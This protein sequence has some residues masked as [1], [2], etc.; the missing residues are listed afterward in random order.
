MHK[1]LEAELVS[2]AHSILKMENKDDVQVLHKK[3]QEIY[4]KLS[5]LKFVDEFLD[6]KPTAVETNKE[7]VLEE[8]VEITEKVVK[9]ETEITIELEEINNDEIVF[10]P[11]QK[12]VISE[13][14]IEEIFET[15]QVF[16]KDDEKDL[17]S[18]QISLEEEFKDAISAD[19]ATNL[20][21]KVTKETPIVEN[22][23]T[24]EIK[25]R[26]LNDALFNKNIQ[27]G[28]N[29]RIAFVKYLFDGSQEDFNRVLSQLNSFTELQEAISFLNDFVKPDYNWQNKE[30]YENRLMDLIERKFS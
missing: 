7:V 14:V 19:I 16:V 6:V 9:K 13:E 2:L 5:V 11:E 4:E 17:P 18:L 27:V 15:K 25:K 12:E 24:E 20:F 26:S 29:D 28:L 3:A 30:E 21:E 8:E 22:I 1:K 23:S 10:E